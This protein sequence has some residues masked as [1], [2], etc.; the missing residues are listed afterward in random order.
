[1]QQARVV[2][3][4]KYIA[5]SIEDARIELVEGKDFIQSFKASNIFPS[6]FLQLLSSGY[7]S[8]NLTFMFEKVAQ[9]MKGEIESK[10]STF[11]SLLEPLVIIFGG[12]IILLIVL[13]ILLPI[14]QMNNMALG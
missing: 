6:L 9:Y 8:G 3:G 1:M 5:Q 4:N 13:A 7:K 12:G 11:L 2:I 10:R 14:M